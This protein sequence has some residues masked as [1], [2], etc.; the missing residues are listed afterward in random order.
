MHNE[1]QLNPLKPIID[2]QQLIYKPLGF[3]TP[4]FRQH[5]WNNEVLRTNLI[6]LPV[7]L[8]TFIFYLISI[9]YIY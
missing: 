4:S 5:V 2:G 9:I 8:L 3:K 1:M 6:S 7:Q